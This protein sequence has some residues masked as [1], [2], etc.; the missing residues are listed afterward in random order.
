M[1]KPAFPNFAGRIMQ[2]YDD[3]DRSLLTLGFMLEY[4]ANNAVSIYRVCVYRHHTRQ[5]IYL[6]DRDIDNS[7]KNLI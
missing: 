2:Q 4:K 7:L 6:I 1:F 5:L 3:D